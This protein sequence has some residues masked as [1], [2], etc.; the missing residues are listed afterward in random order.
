MVLIDYSYLL[1]SRRRRADHAPYVRM[2][3][4]GTNQAVNKDN[5]HATYRSTGT[6]MK[7]LQHDNGSSG[8]NVM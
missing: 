2:R 5:C 3:W 7:R 6:V 4:Q 1:R 8:Y